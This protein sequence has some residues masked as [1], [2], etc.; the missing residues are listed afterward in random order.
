[1]PMPRF[2]LH[3]VFFALLSAVFCTN[4]P[5][6]D[7]P[8]AAGREL[9]TATYGTPI[10]DGSGSDDAWTASDWQPID[11]VWAGSPVNDL[12]DFSGQYKLAWDENNL[13]LLVEIEDDSLR[14]VHADGLDH[15]EEDD[16]LVIFIDENLSGGN[17]QYTFNAFAYH[18]TL[19]GRVTNYAPDST[20]HFFD[21]HCLTRRIDHGHVSTWEIAI[22]IFD[23][24]RFELGGENVPK[25]LE[26]NKKIGFALAYNDNDRSIKRENLIGN[27]PISGAPEK[28]PWMDAS[29]FGVLTLQ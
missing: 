21:E 27:V 25:L 19:D 15:N 2:T 23:G 28:Q 10:L 11:Q 1:M 24:E 12:K 18:I 6:P 7:S 9:L 17:Y 14:D 4:P 20:C 13:Y 5:K 22:R 29:T 3:L 26:A 8:Q 16:C